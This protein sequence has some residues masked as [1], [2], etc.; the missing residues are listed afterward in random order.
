VRFSLPRGASLRLPGHRAPAPLDYLGQPQDLRADWADLTLR[1][2]AGSLGAIENP[3]IVHTLRGS[4]TARL[5]AASFAIG[6]AELQETIDAR[7]DALP[8]LELLASPSAVELVYLVNP[9]RTGMPAS[10]S[11]VLRVTPGADLAVRVVP[12]GDASTDTDGDGVSD[13]GGGNEIV[14]DTAC[15][16]GQRVAC[17][18]NC[19]AAWNPAQLDADGD[20][21]GNACDADLDQDELITGTDLSTLRLCR[22]GSGSPADAGCRE[23][24]LDEDGDADG[25]DEAR[26]LALATEAGGLVLDAAPMPGCGLGPELVP[27][28]V[29]LQA[30]FAAARRRTAA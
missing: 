6:S 24:D 8:S 29:A 28:L 10:A 23:S 15:A 7:A 26:L 11:L 13:D 16:N 19:V 21:R 22:A 9:L 25:A 14:G 4:G 1:L 3:L 20:G 17:D 30:A 12:T 5:G 2:P 27:V 18:D